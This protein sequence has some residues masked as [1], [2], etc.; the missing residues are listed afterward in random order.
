MRPR[1]YSTAHNKLFPAYR[2]RKKSQIHS[3]IFHYDADDFCRT[4]TG[5]AK[6]YVDYVLPIV[7]ADDKQ[8]TYA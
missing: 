4:Y 6:V 1:C 3:G 8:N 2:E 5:C 7:P